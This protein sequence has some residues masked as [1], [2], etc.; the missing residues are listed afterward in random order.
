M[1]ALI[2]IASGVCVILT[3]TGC[4]L[5]DSPVPP[6]RP[7]RTVY[8]EGGDVAPRTLSI[9]KAPSPGAFG[10]TR[11][12]IYPPKIFAVYVPE[13]L[14]K[15]RD[16]KI[17]AHWVYVKLRDSS[18]TQ[19]AIDKEPFCHGE[20]NADDITALRDRVREDAFGRTFIPFETRS[21][22]NSIEPSARSGGRL[23]SRYPGEA[24]PG[25]ER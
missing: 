16:M 6:G 11:P 14:D 8:E 10:K 22:D 19:Q 15:E 25:A 12:V 4:V 9:R 17:G 21:G 20:S 5:V 3:L 2:S 7:V 18:W 1:K 24:D 13:H 23:Q